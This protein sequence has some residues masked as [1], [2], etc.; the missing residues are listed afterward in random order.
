MIDWKKI[1]LKS[2]PY[3]GVFLA[4]AGLSW[5]LK[6]DTVKIEEREVVVEKQVTTEAMKE[7]MTSFEH[8]KQEL[9]KVRETKVVE[10]YHREELETKLPDGTYTKKVTIDKNID[11]FSRETETKILVRVV[12]V[13]KMV[14]VEKKVFVDRIVEKEK[15]VSPVLAQWHVGVFG[16]VNP[17][18][19][20][21]LKVNSYVIGGEVERRI[22][23]PFWLGVWGAGTTTGQGMGGLKVGMEF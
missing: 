8:L 10:K 12:E 18:L 1:A 21:S 14:E 9:Q 2:L 13:D 20:P 5:Q 15:V 4:G 17:Q 3:L 11:S 19:V 6:P 7:L 22:A 16:G 23:G